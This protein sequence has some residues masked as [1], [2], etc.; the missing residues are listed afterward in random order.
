MAPSAAE[1]APAPTPEISES[2]LPDRADCSEGTP[3]E[4]T[5]DAGAVPAC[6]GD[7]P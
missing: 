4:T 2:M 1:T 5:P 6:D 3:L 7:V